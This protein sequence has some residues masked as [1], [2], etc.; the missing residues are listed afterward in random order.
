MTVLVA[1]DDD[2]NFHY[3]KFSLLSLK[4][5][6]IRALDG[7]EAVREC[8]DNPDISLVLMDIKMPIMDG[9]EA[10][11]QIKLFRPELPVV[12]LTAYALA[13][14]RAK[15]LGAGCDEYISKPVKKD[16]L[17]EIIKKFSPQ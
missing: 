6:I 10:T 15:S 9:Y 13:D 5:E 4:I 7:L 14:D 17:V 11:R 1:E 12:A 16:K 8:M 2:I 3:L